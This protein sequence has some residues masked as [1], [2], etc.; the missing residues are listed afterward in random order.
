MIDYL[1]IIEPF[2]STFVKILKLEY[3][4]NLNTIIFSRNLFQ[5]PQYWY[6]LRISKSSC[7]G[8]NFA[9]VSIGVSTILHPNKPTSDNMSSTYFLYIRISFLDLS[10]I[11]SKKYRKAPRSFVWKRYSKYCLCLYIV[12]HYRSWS[13]CHLY[14]QPKVSPFP[15]ADK[16]T[17]WSF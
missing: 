12:V 17:M 3:V 9:V 1:S 10:T 8:N 5:V 14:I 11:I 7:F 6:L 15:R 16:K 13:R 2:R 4:H